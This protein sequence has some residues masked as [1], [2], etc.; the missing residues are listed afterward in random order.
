MCRTW[1]LYGQEYRLSCEGQLEE[2]SPRFYIC[3]SVE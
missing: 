1:E 3:V 2:M